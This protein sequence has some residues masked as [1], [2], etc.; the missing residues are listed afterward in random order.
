M[1]RGT[2]SSRF[3]LI[4]RRASAMLVALVFAL[5]I[6]AHGLGERAEDHLFPT[7]DV[8]LT[9]LSAQAHNSPSDALCNH[10]HSEHHQMTPCAVLQDG[11]HRHGMRMVYASF[12]TRAASRETAPPHGPPKA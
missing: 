12:E 8:A 9:L 4:A 3:R 5:G 2:R 6:A 7:A 1:A 11:V 10:V